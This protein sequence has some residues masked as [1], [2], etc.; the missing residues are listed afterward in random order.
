MN[1]VGVILGNRAMSTRLTSIIKWGC[2]VYSIVF[3]PRLFFS[4]GGQSQDSQ[5]A[6]L[7]V[8]MLR[9]S[10]ELSPSQKSVLAELGKEGYTVDKLLILERGDEYAQ[11]SVKQQRSMQL[12]QLLANDSLE[13]IDVLLCQAE[14]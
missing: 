10:D 7:R 11:K 14:S 12:E 3:L 9:D 4:D 8:G 13:D 6:S 1:G 5:Q 2:I